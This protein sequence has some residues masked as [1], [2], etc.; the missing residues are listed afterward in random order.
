MF[1][2][3][4]RQA[5]QIVPPNLDITTVQLA[6]EKSFISSASGQ[7]S[8]PRQAVKFVKRVRS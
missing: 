6:A 5:A 2:L 8:R 7:R 3:Q 1:M 4:A